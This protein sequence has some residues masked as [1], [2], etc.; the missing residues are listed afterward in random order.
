MTEIYAQNSINF[1]TLYAIDPMNGNVK[2]TSKSLR[3]KTA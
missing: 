3:E 1:W 2:L